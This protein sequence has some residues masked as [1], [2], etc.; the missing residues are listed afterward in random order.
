MLQRLLD[1]AEARQLPALIAEWSERSDALSWV[2][3]ALQLDLPLL[4]ERPELVLTCLYRRCHWLGDREMFYPKRGAVPRAT[5]PGMPP[6]KP[7]TLPTRSPMPLPGVPLAPEYD[8]GAGDE[9]GERTT[10]RA[11]IA[12]PLKPQVLRGLGIEPLGPHKRAASEDIGIEVLTGE[13]VL[14]PR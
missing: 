1:E 13:R 3:R 12:G 8:F 9:T 4:I 5:L 11:A 2:A 7:P 10:E 6:M 14:E